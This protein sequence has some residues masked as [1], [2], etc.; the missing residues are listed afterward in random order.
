[1]LKANVAVR[2]GTFDLDIALE[3]VP[4]EIVAV[5]GPNGAGKTTFLRGVAGLVPLRRGRSELDDAVLNDVA[6]RIN[7]TPDNRP[8]C[9]RFQDYL[10]FTD[11][12]ALGNVALDI[13]AR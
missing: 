11:L 9:V 12:F 13:R 6:Q 8:M 2:L 4:G 7:V 10:L 3:A 5:L 1:M